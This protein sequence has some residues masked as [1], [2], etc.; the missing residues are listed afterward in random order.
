MVISKLKIGTYLLLIALGIGIG[1]LIFGK[2]KTEFIKVPAVVGSISPAPIHYLEPKG[3]PLRI[4]WR[5]RV[6][7]QKEPI[8][9]SL[10]QAY[11]DL[12]SKFQGLELDYQ[13][14][15]MFIDAIKG[16]STYLS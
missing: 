5:D 9:D 6:I 15:K 12:E 14:A 16:T 3:E 1:Y 11:K 2:T 10:L 8:N 4:I 13:Q 7:E